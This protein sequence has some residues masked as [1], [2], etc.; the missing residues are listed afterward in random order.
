MELIDVKAIGE[1]IK[2]E[3][4]AAGLSQSQLATL[5]GKTL[6]T[7]QKYESGEIEPSFSMINEIAIALCI[8]AFSLLRNPN[9]A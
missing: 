4:K 7:V 5:I 3:R 6:R 1:N 8:S 9:A 2:N